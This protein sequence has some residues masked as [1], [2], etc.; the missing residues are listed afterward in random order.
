MA[1]IP[2]AV[3]TEVIP[4][5]IGKEGIQF[6]HVIGAGPQSDQAGDDQIGESG[7]VVGAARLVDEVK[8]SS[9]IPTPRCVWQLGPSE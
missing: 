1:M 6:N 5:S 7:I 9:S 2:D 3:E 4:F 8:A